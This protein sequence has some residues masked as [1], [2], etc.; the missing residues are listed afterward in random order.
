MNCSGLSG[1][2]AIEYLM[3]YGWMLLVVA[4]VGG[5]VFSVV[6]S[7]S[8]ESISGFS[9]EDVLVDDFG[10]TTDD[11]LQLS[12]R[13]GSGQ[14]LTVS[15][16]N[17]SDSN[18]GRYVYKEFVDS[19]SVDGGEENVFTLPN[20]SNRGSS[21]TLKIEITYDSN[22]LQ[23]LVSSGSISGDLEV[24]KTRVITEWHN[25]KELIRRIDFDDGKM[26]GLD[27]NADEKYLAVSHDSS[28]H[29]ISIYNYSENWAL[30]ERFG[31]DSTGSELTVDSVNQKLITRQEG[32]VDASSFADEG[33]LDNLDYPGVIDS[34]NG[35][36]AA[37][38]SSNNVS[39]YEFND[40][41]KS[42]KN[43]SGPT[44]TIWEINIDNNAGYVAAGS[45]DGNVYIWD[46]EN[47]NLDQTFESQEGSVWSIE[48]DEERDMMVFGDNEGMTMVNMNNWNIENTISTEH[49][50]R[51]LSIFGKNSYT[52]AG[53]QN[54]PADGEVL[55]Y[56]SNWIL[57]DKLAEDEG[58]VRN[59][60]L[61]PAKPW[62]AFS[63]GNT[64]DIFIYEIPE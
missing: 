12:L 43:L 36:I 11:S 30:D 18:E 52:A 1:Q 58:I 13:D 21:S 51:S 40:G 2:S 26:R 48:F 27:W 57:V 53:L 22:G 35:Y 54:G 6:Q 15:S 5:A 3:T 17:V 59:M 32:I 45:M 44:D 34:D 31:P 46:T 42:V 47:W 20:I 37:A 62:M 9:G 63:S 14:G 24:S 56:D 39:I 33:N 64:E 28:D 50:V 23:N 16:I 10:I 19:K 7:Q 8:V 41:Y 61:H 49:R 29:S 55:I 38:T 4:V 60:V 25:E